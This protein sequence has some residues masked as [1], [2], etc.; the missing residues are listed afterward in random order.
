M[1]SFIITLQGTHKHVRD[2]LLRDQSQPLP[3]NQSH[4]SFQEERL[5]DD[6][7]MTPVN[8]LSNYSPKSNN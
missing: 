4:M 2:S 1:L 3:G 5:K 8:S 7:G 6:A